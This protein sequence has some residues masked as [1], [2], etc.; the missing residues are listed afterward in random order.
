VAKNGFALQTF[1]L[2]FFVNIFVQYIST[3]YN[4]SAWPCA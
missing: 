1:A 4:C 2:N 3:A